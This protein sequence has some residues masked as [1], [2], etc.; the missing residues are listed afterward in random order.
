MKASEAKKHGLS[1]LRT[2]SDSGRFGRVYHL[3]SEGILSLC[4]QG[5]TEC[6]KVFP[7]PDDRIPVCRVCIKRMEEL[8][9]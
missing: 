6:V 7:K 8:S 2:V 5:E 9:K 1:V 4:A 3:S